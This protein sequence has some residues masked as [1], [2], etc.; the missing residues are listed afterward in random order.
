MR[1]CDHAKMD[2]EQVARWVRA[3][4]RAWRTAGT[5]HLADLFTPD[6]SYLPS[7]WARALNG[8]DELAEFWEAEREGPGEQFALTSDVVAVDGSVAIVRVSVDYL[9]AKVGRWRDL[10]VLRFGPDG[11]CTAFEEWPF[12][13]DQRD[14][15]EGQG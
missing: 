13:P 9:D 6:V 14:G 7:P 3:Y 2:R 1:S 5:D 4:E 12:A 8:L 15:H 11:R 10:W